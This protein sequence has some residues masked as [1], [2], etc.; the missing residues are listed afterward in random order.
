M[1]KINNL[2]FSYGDEPIL[3]NICFQAEQGCVTSVIGPNG[4][5]KTTLLLCIS[6][7]IFFSGNIALDEIH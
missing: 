3:K 7:L 4:T 6:R 5:G 1:L 2:S